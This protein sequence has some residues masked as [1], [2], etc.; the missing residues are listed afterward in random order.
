MVP[1]A[2]LGDLPGHEQQVAR[3]GRRARSWR[4]GSVHRQLIPSV[5]RRCLDRL[6][7]GL[8][9]LPAIE[10]RLGDPG[11]EGRTLHWRA[12]ILDNPWRALQ[13][14]KRTSEP[15][16]ERRLRPEPTSGSSV[17]ETKPIL[18]RLGREAATWLCRRWF[19]AALAAQPA[20]SPC[21]RPHRAVYDITLDKARTAPACRRCPAAWSTS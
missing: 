2:G 13:T 5:A 9:F 6:R 10:G 8:P 7:H 21:C 19:S 14:I 1:S 3:D 16:D 4:P 17:P 12:L 11:A 18:K 20:A 15:P